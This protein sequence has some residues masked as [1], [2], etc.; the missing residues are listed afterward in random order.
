MATV[1]LCID[2]GSKFISIYQKGIG[3]VLREPSIAIVTKGRNNKM[4]IRDA[5]YRAESIMT[6]AMGGAKIVAPIQEGI[7]VDEEMASMLLEHFLSKILPDTLIKPRVKAIVSICLSSTNSD[8]RAVEKCCL[9]AGIKEVTL[10][11][12]P[13]CL[14]AY[15][16]SIGGLFVDIGGGKTEIAA[17]TAQGGIATGCSVNIAG[18]AF[19]NAIIDSLYVNYGVK[20]G[21]YTIE[22]LKK[23]A[24]SFYINDEGN[25][26][27]S[28]GG[29]DGTPRSLFVSAA[30]MRDAVIPLVDD[31]IEVI[32]SVLNQTPPELSAEILRKGIFVSGGSLHIPGLIEYI[33]QALEL[34]ITPLKDVDN[35]VAIGGGVFFENKDLLSTMLGV[36]LS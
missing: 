13:L 20:L 36:R 16:S 4:E 8:R 3:L 34:A 24:L 26:A 6:T 17:V 5:G 12:G 31:I 11:E 7:V 25:Y 14:L 35:A 1:E 21:E 27:V 22:N 19:N 23:S 9:K 10:V 29:K 32:M 18:D 28:G 30:D 15:T 33:E 2:L